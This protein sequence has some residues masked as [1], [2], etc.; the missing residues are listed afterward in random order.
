MY[1]DGYP[2]LL[3]VGSVEPRKNHIA[4]IKTMERLKAAGYHHHLLIAGGKGWMVEPILKY[5]QTSSAADQIVFLDFIPQAELAALYSG[6]ECLLLPS[7]YEGFGFTALEAMASGTPVI[8]SN[9][10]SLPE[11]VGNAALQV[12]PD[13]IAGLTQSV[14]NVLDQPRLAKE[15]THRGLVNASRFRWDRCA[16]ETVDVYRKAIAYTS[17]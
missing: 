7:Y 5:A 8:C 6:A 14:R 2:Y 17:D 1:S 9:A 12:E 15:I 3:M 11:I 16:Q 4:A 10:G 13:D